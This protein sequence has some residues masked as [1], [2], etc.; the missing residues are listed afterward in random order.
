MF[1][2]HRIALKGLL[3]SLMLSVGLGFGQNHDVTVVDIL[4]PIGNVNVGETIFPQATVANVG[5]QPAPPFP[6]I[7]V[8][9]ASNGNPVYG[10]TQ[11]LVNG[12]PPGLQQNVTANQPWIPAQPGE[13]SVI[14]FCNAGDRNPQND[15][16]RTTVSV[17]PGLLSRQQAIALVQQEVIAS[18]PFQNQLVAFLYNN[19][20]TDSVLHNGDTVSPWDSSFTENI[21]TE[22]Y[23][24]WL[25]YE[26]EKE[27]WHASAFVFVN[28]SNGAILVRDAQ[29]WPVVN[30]VE[31]THFMED[32]NASPDRVHGSYPTSNLLF[33]YETVT[34]NNK[35]DWA[36]IVVGRNLHGAG[37]RTARENDIDR[38]K[39]CLNGAA[40]GPQIDGGNILVVPGAN[41][42][43]A[44]IKEVCDELDKLKGKACRKLFFHYIGHGEPG[45]MLLKKE[46]KNESET[47]TYEKLACKLL[48]LG[49]Q[50][51]C[52]VLE[53]C[54]SGS[55]I[56]A[57]QNKEI[58]V[59]G[60]KVK[61]KGAV[62]TSSPGNKT[63][64]READGAPFN[65]GM[66]E[67]CKDPNADLN[68]DGKVTIIEA[69][70]WARSRN[71]TVAGDGPQG[72]T[73]GDGRTIVF[74]P[75][76]KREFTNG[77]DSGGTLHYEVFSVYYKILEGAAGGK[78]DSLVCRQTLYVENRAGS[79]HRG[80][81]EVE[82]VCTDSRGRQT[83]IHRYRPVLDRKQRICLTDLPADCK[84]VNVR[85][86]RGASTTIARAEEGTSLLR[87]GAIYAKGEF[88]FQEI[89]LAVVDGQKYENAVTPLSGWGL[90]IDPLMFTASAIVDTEV[91]LVRG[92]M[93]D[94]ATQGN[95]IAATVINNSASDTT[96][97]AI[98]ALLFDSLDVDIGD[99]QTFIARALDLHAGLAV[100]TGTLRLEEALINFKKTASGLVKKAGK[101]IVRNTT[102]RPEEGFTYNLIVRGEL[103]WEG[104]TLVAPRNGLR[105]ENPRA[106]I[107]SGG[108]LLSQ[109][110]G[111]Y[112]GGDQSRT[113]LDFFLV[114]GSMENGVAADSARNCTLRNLRV[115]NSGLNDVALRTQSNVT[116]L[117]CSF[118]ANKVQVDNSS[119][120]TRAWTTQFVFAN[121]QDETLSG[122]VV[123]VRDAAGVVV[124]RDTSE[125]SGFSEA[126]ALIQYRQTGA[127]SVFHT[128]HQLKVSYAGRDTL[129][130]HTA[131][132]Q[133]IREITL[134][135]IV[136]GVAE[137]DEALPSVFALQQNYPNPFG[138][139]RGA[140]ATQITYA[141]P[142][143]TEVNFVVYNLLG[144]EV[145]NQ[146]LG[147]KVAGRYTLRLDNE[148]LMPGVY[149]YELRAGQMR[150]HK[151]M[152]V[153]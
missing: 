103:E 55:A 95:M 126:F 43:G 7:F 121:A 84:R 132:A 110:D 85:K 146:A 29:S 112:L 89:E 119:Q 105:L 36:V 133:I 8:I 37:E 136:S 44:T 1:P 109:K 63:T 39:E 100:N 2:S 145:L 111:L 99:G 140:A 69:V 115:E 27:W 16:L 79:P 117:D 143:P 23:F 26:P 122:V 128:P 153:R 52:I 58:T 93:P 56:A 25:D 131:N 48:E 90:S 49:V 66:H 45:G 107:F 61:L 71:P 83:V 51:V 35:A 5:Q 142:E 108:V 127:A 15:T 72:A 24:F 3:F 78:K 11:T 30:G 81:R 102:L 141:L 62:V 28:A 31:L 150:L 46:G 113:A 135:F 87:R 17:S 9:L 134:P 75:P 82:V 88:I 106:Q 59:N 42:M 20:A 80:E 38:I 147:R 92:V 54:Y 137:R 96:A 129:I 148:A 76:V 91:V 73:L 41:T 118:N 74:L 116:M 4:A 21:P 123:E 149:F 67:C 22:T 125:A 98:H 144:Q 19:A 97:L 104:A 13:F 101:L 14:A 57:L 6:L 124:G 151:K 130:T 50:E 94:T 40:L 33:N 77:E 10:P 114:D 65:K 120:L 152:V 138:S 12:L 68:K 64:T 53:T 34:T 139:S 70:A 60:K 86:V 32:G 47:L 18:S